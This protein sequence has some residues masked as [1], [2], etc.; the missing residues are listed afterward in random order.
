M[1]TFHDKGDLHGI[2]VVVDTHGPTIYIGRCW[3]M[4]ERQV[5]LVDVDEHEAGKDGRS[6]EEFVKQA[7]RVGVWKKHDRLVIPHDEVASVTRL[8]AIA[9]D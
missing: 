3:E 5:V 9:S 7:A 2:T 4:D 6:K 8:G 1:G